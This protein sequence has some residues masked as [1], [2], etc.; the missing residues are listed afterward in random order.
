MR[1][2]LSSIDYC[3]LRVPYPQ[4]HRSRTRSQF[5]STP[6]ALDSTA[7]GIPTN[8]LDSMSS[9]EAGGRDTPGQ[10]RKSVYTR[11]G[12]HNGRESNRNRLAQPAIHKRHAHRTPQIVPL[13]NPLWGRFGLL[14]LLPRAVE[15]NPFGVKSP[16]PERSL[17]AEGKPE[18]NLMRMGKAATDGLVLV[19]VLEPPARGR[20]REISSQPAKN[21]VHCSAELFIA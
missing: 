13:S 1:V 11:N 3:H 6:T 15:S 14:D 21:F 12:F 9:V 19:L 2:K 4:G 7:R 16:E 8:R 17:G 20:G 18:L 10:V 5:R